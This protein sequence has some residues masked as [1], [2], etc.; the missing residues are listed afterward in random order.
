MRHRVS[1]YRLN[2]KKGNRNALRRNLIINLYQNNSI[3][4]TKAKAKA[5][6]SEAEKMITIAKNS[7][8]GSEIDRVNA[9]RLVAASLANDGAVR[10]LFDEIAP[11]F[12][13]RNGGYT[14]MFNL[15]PRVGDSAEMVILEL[16]EE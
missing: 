9:R 16:L 2:R 1:G 13:S 15:G 14:R 7:A 11:R 5:I 4:T 10:V 8:K 6:R 12:E 3:R